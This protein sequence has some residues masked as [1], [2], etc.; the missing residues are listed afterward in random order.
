MDKE[1]RIINHCCNL[2]SAVVYE[3]SP[4]DSAYAP[5]YLAVL[6]LMFRSVVNAIIQLTGADRE[7]LVSDLVAQLKESLLMESEK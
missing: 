1:K 6:T 2:L 4:N 5:K 3:L 7:K